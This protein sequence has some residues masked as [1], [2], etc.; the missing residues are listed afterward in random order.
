MI[1]SQRSESETVR[2][3]ARDMPRFKQEDVVRVPFPYTHGDTRQRR[4]AL[5]V[6]HGEIG[7][8]DSLLWVVMDYECCEPTLVRRC[9]GLTSTSRWACQHHP[10]CARP[11]LQPSTPD[12]PTGSDTCRKSSG[13]ALPRSCGV[14]SAS[15]TSIHCDVVRHC[16][17]PGNTLDNNTSR[18]RPACTGDPRRSRTKNPRSYADCV[19]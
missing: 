6:S 8:A 9:I 13:G 2:P 16:G 3:T 11:R 15:R 4:P 7:E 5:V 10:A 18:R 14:I 19:S 12:A 1:R 17:R